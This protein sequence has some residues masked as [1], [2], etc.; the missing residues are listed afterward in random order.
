MLL[1]DCIGWLVLV[2]C[3]VL[4]G[5]LFGRFACLFGLPG[6]AI[7]VWLVGGLFVY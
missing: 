4:V 5:C 6:W 1:V 7:F 2:V 3:V